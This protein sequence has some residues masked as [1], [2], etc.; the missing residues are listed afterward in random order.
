MGYLMS[1][2]TS[3]TEEFTDSNVTDLFDKCK[4]TLPLTLPDFG[5]HS[6]GLMCRSFM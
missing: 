5:A 4:Q 6:K 1:E 2:L 3:S